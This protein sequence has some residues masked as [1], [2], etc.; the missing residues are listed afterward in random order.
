M[1]IL[2]I[3]LML[4]AAPAH[5]RLVAADVDTRKLVAE[6]IARVQAKLDGGEPLTNAEIKRVLRLIL[7]I[8]ERN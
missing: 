8:L 1:K 3:V 5:A 2:A 6:E 7:A 4:A